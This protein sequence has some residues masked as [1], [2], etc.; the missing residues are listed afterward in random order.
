MTQPIAVNV[1]VKGPLFEKKIDD[2][3]KRAMVD[4]CLAKMEKRMMRG[5]RGKGA[6]RNIVTTDM[7]FGHAAA[8]VSMSLSGKPRIKG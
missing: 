5:G 4:E 3:A 2:V 6:K 8:A 1:T 7:T